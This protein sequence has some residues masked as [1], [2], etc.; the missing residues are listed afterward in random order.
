[1]LYIGKA[2]CNEKCMHGLGRDFV[3]LFNKE[4]FYSI[5]LVPG[6][7]PGQPI[8]KIEKSNLSFS[9]LLT[10]FPKFLD[11]VNEVI[12]KSNRWGWLG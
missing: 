6:S 11:L 8:W 5:R 4:V 12:R 3:Y 7:S 9:F 10:S 2:V 1:M